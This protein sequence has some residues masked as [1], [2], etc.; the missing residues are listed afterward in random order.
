[1]GFLCGKII[2]SDE[3]SFHIHLCRISDIKRGGSIWA[4]DFGVEGINRMIRSI[5]FTGE[6]Y[7]S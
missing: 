6:A 5:T 1:M 4:E 3:I 2:S 7:L